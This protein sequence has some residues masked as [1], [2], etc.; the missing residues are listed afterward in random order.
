MKLEQAGLRSDT[1]WTHGL[2]HTLSVVVLV[3]GLIISIFVLGNLAIKGV[4]S[5]LE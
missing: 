4:P 1:L 3:L 2:S 5:G